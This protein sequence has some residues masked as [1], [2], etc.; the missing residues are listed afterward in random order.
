MKNP[1]TVRQK[2]CTEIDSAKAVNDHSKIVGTSGTK[3]DIRRPKRSI[4]KPALSDPNGDAK[5]LMLAYHEPVLLSIYSGSVIL[6]TCGRKIAVNP[7]FMATE[8]IV[9]DTIAVSNIYRAE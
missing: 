9:D 6:R 4:T 5:L 8:A 3:S 1:I 7:M 2:N